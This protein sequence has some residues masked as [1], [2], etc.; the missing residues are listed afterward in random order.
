MDKDKTIFSKRLYRQNCVKTKIGSG[1][2]AE[3]IFVKDLRIFHQVDLSDIIII[4]NSVLSF[5]I[6]LDNGIPILPFNDNKNDNELLI[7]ANY[8][9]ELS[10]C[11]DIH[12]ANRK[13]MKYNYQ[14][15]DESPSASE[16]D[17]KNKSNKSIKSL[18]ASEITD[19]SCVSDNNDLEFSYS[20]CD[21]DHSKANLLKKNFLEF[22]KNF[23]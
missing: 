23:R 19:D 17:N 21:D 20:Y 1:E 5:A 9:K 10:N 13:Y 7:L 22:K 11:K 4:D 6:H 18:V 12:V 3:N 2:N 8:L 16:D 14:P 15:K